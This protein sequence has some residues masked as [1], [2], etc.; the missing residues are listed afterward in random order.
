VKFKFWAKFTKNVFMASLNETTPTAEQTTMAPYMVLLL[1]VLAA[2]IG[3]LLGSALAFGW[4]SAQGMEAQSALLELNQDSPRSMRHAVRVVN[5][6]NHFAT[7]TLSAVVVVL[8]AYRDRWLGYLRLHRS[9]TGKMLA[10]GILFVVFSFPFA[11]LAYWLNMQLPLPEWMMELETSTQE[12]IRAL[13]IM[14]NPTE[15]LF[16]LLVIAVL[17]AVG[18][19][20]LFRGGIQQQLQRSISPVAAIWITAIIFSAIHMQFAGFFPR[21]LLGAVLGYVFYWSRNLWVPIGAHFVTNAMQV[22]GVY[23]AGEDLTQIEM[24]APESANWASG[25]LSLALTIGVG[26]LMWRMFKEKTTEQ[27]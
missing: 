25:L 8:I 3:A 27:A 6:L 26:Y 18:E 20:L 15:L 2:L 11:Q 12:M 4:L 1:L 24:E 13:L 23:V 14:E 9:P 10:L 7:F 21:M 5:L 19:E 22:V 16:N 17:P